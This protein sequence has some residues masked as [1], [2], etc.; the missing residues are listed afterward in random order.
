ML[1]DSSW[2]RAAAAAAGAAPSVCREGNS[3]QA[4]G[5]HSLPWMIK[6]GSSFP[7]EAVA[8]ENSNLGWMRPCA[9]SFKNFS[10]LLRIQKC[11]TFQ[12]VCKSNKVTSGKVKINYVNWNKNLCITG[13]WDHDLLRPAND[14][15]LPFEPVIKLYFS[16]LTVIKTKC[17]NKLNLDLW[18]SKHWTKTNEAYSHNCSHLK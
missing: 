6:Q 18:I 12:S 1:P 2:C 14:A 5:W 17:W 4:R 3:D 10:V 8:L 11:K 13:G 9:I 7:G 15:I 16:A